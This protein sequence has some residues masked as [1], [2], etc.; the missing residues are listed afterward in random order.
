M[1]YIYILKSKKDDSKYIGYTDNLKRRLAE[2]NN[3]KNKSTKFKAPFNLIYYESYK[4]K[5]DSK[6]REK[7]LK[8]FAQAYNQLKRRIRNSLS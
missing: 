2:H 8:R 1:F 6:Y 4:S 5:A 7:N 3:L